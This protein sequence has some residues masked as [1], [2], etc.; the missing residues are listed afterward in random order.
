VNVRALTLLVAL[1]LWCITPGVQAAER[2]LHWDALKVEAHLDAGGTLDIFERHTMVFTGEWNGGE[3]VFN[4][5][6][7][8][9]LEF[10]GIERVDASTGLA[11]SLWETS[12]PDNVDDYTWTD[13]RTLRWRSRLP[14]YPPFA[15][16][17]GSMCCITGFPAFC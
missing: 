12:V 5:R 10:M 9:N 2:E 7:H 11:H 16:Q 3:R 14:S 6:A 1:M 13:R 8:Q 4:V 15:K 17:S